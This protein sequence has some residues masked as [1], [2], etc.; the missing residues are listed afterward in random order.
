QETLNLDPLLRQ[1]DKP[2]I[3]LAEAEKLKL[4]AFLRTL[5]DKKFITDKKLSEQ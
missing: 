2:G 4:L 3:A 5:N 1:T